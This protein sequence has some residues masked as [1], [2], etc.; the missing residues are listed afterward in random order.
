VVFFSDLLFA[1][2]LQV[3]KLNNFHK[4]LHFESISQLLGEGIAREVNLA[5]IWEFTQGQDAVFA[6]KL[7]VAKVEDF[8][9]RHVGQIG[10]ALELVPIQIQL[11][12]VGHV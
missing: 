12:Q 11:A 6:C 8:E 9:L 3:S 2:Q 4:Q 5:Q 7:V 1:D 10:K